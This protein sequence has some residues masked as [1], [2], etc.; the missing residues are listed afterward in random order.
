MTLTR[1]RAGAHSRGCA[2]LIAIFCCSPAV[3][4]FAQGSTPTVELQVDPPAAGSEPFKIRVQLL[5]LADPAQSWTADVQTGESVRF[6]LVPPGSYRLISGSVERRVEVA[7]GDELTITLGSAGQNSRELRI[8]ARDR[9]AYGTRFNSTMIEML[10]QS[11][12]VYGLIERSDPLVITERMEGGGAY[13]EPQRL[14]A[15]GAS[16]TQTTFRIGDADIPDPDP[17]GSTRL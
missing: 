16:W 11:G 9:S 13:P 15:S 17:T 14:G 4:L 8:A 3:N 6:R 12:G 10:P 5:S 2:A 1:L 7:S